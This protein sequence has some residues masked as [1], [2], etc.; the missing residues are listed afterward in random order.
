MDNWI[1]TRPIKNTVTVSS[2]DK[3]TII[4]RISEQPLQKYNFAYTQPG[5]YDVTFHAINQNRKN[6]LIKMKIKIKQ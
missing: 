2:G 6:S 4:K 5:E 3:G 1:I